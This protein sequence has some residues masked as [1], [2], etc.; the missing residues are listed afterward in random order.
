M[1]LS[2]KKPNLAER[3]PADP[4]ALQGEPGGA[5]QGKAAGA[6]S[7]WAT[8]TWRAGNLGTLL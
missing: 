8:W 1:Y 6:D 7:A 2:L 5:D 4:G 3:E